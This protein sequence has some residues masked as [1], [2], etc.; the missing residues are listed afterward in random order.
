MRGLRTVIIL[1]VLCLPVAAPATAQDPTPDPLNLA[2]NTPRPSTPAAVDQYALRLWTSVDLTQL[3]EDQLARLNQED[4]DPTIFTAQLALYEL[5]ERF[6]ATFE[7]ADL[8]ERL[9]PLALN[10]PPGTVDARPIVR[11][12]VERLMTRNRDVF[13]PALAATYNVGAFRVIV[14]P[15]GATPLSSTDVILRIN[16]DNSGYQDVV[17]A[18]F[19]NDDVSVLPAFPD[20]PAAPFGDATAVELLRVD[21]INGNGSEEF[22]VAV[23]RE[24][25]LNRDLYVYGVR[26]D[27]AFEL[28]I[29][30]EQMIVAG[31]PQWED[32]QFSVLE[33]RL[34]ANSFWGCSE[35]RR[36]LWSWGNNTF[37]PQPQSV[38]AAGS[39]LAC[40]LDAQGNVFTLAPTDAIAQLEPLI[41][42]VQ[43]V[44][45]VTRVNMVLATLYLLNGQPNEAAQY[46]STVIE[47]APEGSPRARQAQTLLEA[48]GQR[49]VS[50]LTVCS[51]LTLSAPNPVCDIEAVTARV[52]AD[53]FNT[54]ESIEAQ[55]E[56]RRI[57]YGE[58]TML[59]QIGR[60]SRPA[61]YLLLGEGLW[62]AFNQ[63]DD[64]YTAE[65]IDPPEGVETEI[66]T[67]ASTIDRDNMVFLL[68]ESDERTAVVTALDTLEANPAV[69]L[70]PPDL[71][72]LRA[73]ANDF[74]GNRQI[75]RQQYYDLWQS[76]V[77]G[78]WGQFAARHL[79]RR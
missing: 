37:F 10:A 57:P 5:E 29:P 18:R 41:A 3:L 19:S 4:S 31:E 7:D 48:I 72:F 43:P 1:L 73:M 50:P 32:G 22:A 30:P 25:T 34:Q 63:A 17:F 51:T 62:I 21:D 39:G 66:T 58:V 9:L 65:I 24:G 79:E 15:V 49:D 61:A 71:Q 55:L 26:G 20:Y 23:T 33:R 46:A 11:P 54:T 64:V 47:D 36:V 28:T 53:P 14:Q 27:E 78:V 16:D 74:A 77:N 42:D 52:L 8:Q 56:E 35:R 59:Q 44:S 70:L 40:T 60:R 12:Y 68:F 38:F 6:P 69:G 76:D 45:T 13:N 2:T 75:A 67:P